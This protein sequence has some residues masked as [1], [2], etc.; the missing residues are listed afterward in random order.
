MPELT[1]STISAVFGGPLL[2][3]ILLGWPVMTTVLGLMG[4]ERPLGKPY[5]RFTVARDTVRGRR[6]P[7]R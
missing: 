7:R 4:S 3:G 6:E 1:D 5:W 2:V